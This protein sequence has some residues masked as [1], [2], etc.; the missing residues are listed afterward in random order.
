MKICVGIVKKN[1]VWE[2]FFFQNGV[3]FEEVNF[4]N[5]NYSVIVV[6]DFLDEFKKEKIKTYLK[7]GGNVLTSTKFLKNLFYLKT[8]K[9]YVKSIL[10][11]RD[12]IFKTNFLID[13]NSICEIVEGANF[14][15]DKHKN[16]T[17]F[18]TEKFGGKLISFPFELDEI[19]SLQK[20][21]TKNFFSNTKIFPYEKV[22][23]VSKNE[24]RKLIFNAIEF[25]HHK[26]KLPF[27]HLNFFPNAQKNIFLFRV[28]TDKANKFEVENLY[29]TIEKY[30][31]KA[32]WFLDVKTQ[33]SNFDSYKK[34]ENQELALHGYYH[35]SFETEKRFFE[36]ISIAKNILQKNN[37][38][39]NGFA[40]P[41]GEWSFKMQTEIEKFNFNYS[42]EFSFDYD[43]IPSFPKNSN[44]LQIPIHPICI[45]S[46][47]NANMT[48]PEMKNYFYFEIQKKKKL[49]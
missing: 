46:L 3:F 41:F 39:P 47:K 21:Q 43:N 45:G 40:T 9:M 42:S 38:F 4:E 2:N 18:V 13:I 24:L 12:E 44:T 17:T 25:L 31:I 35:N 20:T 15:I 19:L 1:F 14:L 22:S 8:Q 30:G 34:F 16:Y 27:I 5:L 28:D 29:K 32:T 36:N 33:L 37:F 48:E 10:P 7:N 26:K 23:S 11:D 6:N 49:Q